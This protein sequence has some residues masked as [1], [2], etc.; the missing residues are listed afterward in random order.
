MREIYSTAPEMKLHTDEMKSLTYFS[1]ACSGAFPARR[2][3]LPSAERTAPHRRAKPLRFK[4]RKWRV[5]G[6]LNSLLPKILQYL[7]TI[8][9][10]PYFEIG[11]VAEKESG[12]AQDK[13]AFRPQ[14]FSKFGRPLLCATGTGMAAVHGR[15]LSAH[16]DAE[17]AVGFGAHETGAME[18]AALMSLRQLLGAVPMDAGQKMAIGELIG[19]IAEELG[20]SKDALLRERRE[21]IEAVE[22]LK[23]SEKQVAQERELRMQAVSEVSKLKDVLLQERR[24]RVEAVEA[25]ED[26][27]QELKVKSGRAC[28]VMG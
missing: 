10:I 25:I 15:V 5:L 28:G 6:K 19:A 8:Y 21:H 23:V 3:R 1:S 11:Y 22:A 7:S 20:E 4:A 26:R 2:T 13:N 9:C 17:A 27:L 16:P 18:S 14:H 12:S 24:L